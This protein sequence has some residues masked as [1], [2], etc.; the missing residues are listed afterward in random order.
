MAGLITDADDISN[1]AGAKISAGT[2]EDFV[3]GLSGERFNHGRPSL[4]DY[5]TDRGVD[6]GLSF[7]D[8]APKLYVEASPWAM[9]NIQTPPDGARGMMVERNGHLSFGALAGE[10]PVAY[11]E[12]QYSVSFGQSEWNEPQSHV[13]QNDPIL[14]ENGNVLV[15]GSTE[16]Y[17]Y[18]GYHSYEDGI[19]TLSLG[20]YG[21]TNGGLHI[22]GS[23]HHE[24]NIT[25]SDME[26]GLEGSA[27]T[28]Y[29]DEAGLFAKLGAEINTILH[30][31]SDTYGY[32]RGS[33]QA[34][35][36]DGY[37]TQSVEMGIGSTLGEKIPAPMELG[38]Q[39][40][41]QEFKPA[42]GIGLKF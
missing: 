8:N 20:G 3:G 26:F 6:A 2:I 17:N 29:N 12:G 23:A 24:R 25:I 11:I 28:G 19:T 21:D 38:V 16:T 33:W 39:Y 15:P 10:D 9:S 40:D 34:A 31:P 36:N 18:D 35:Q 30:E 5:F 41:G 37:D 1:P 32:L 27:A 7:H 22:E 13:F 42:A 4:S 14:D